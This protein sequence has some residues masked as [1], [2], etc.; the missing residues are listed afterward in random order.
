LHVVGI[1]GHKKTHTL[2]AVDQLGRRADKTTVKAT[3]S[4]HVQALKWIARFGQ[5]LLA[6]EDCRHLTRRFEAD[7]LLAP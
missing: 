7:L 4:G 6:I 1:G 2:V 5:V 3:P